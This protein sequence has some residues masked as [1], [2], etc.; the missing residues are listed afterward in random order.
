MYMKVLFPLPLTRN[1]YSTC[2][3]FQA[4][5]FCQVRS[6]RIFQ[7]SNYHSMFSLTFLSFILFPEQEVH[8]RDKDKIREIVSHC[9]VVINLMGQDYQTRNFSF[10]DIHI[11]VPR[12]LAKICKEEKV[13][14]FIHI[15]ALGAEL[16]SRSKFLRTKVTIF[17]Q[18]IKFVC[19]S[20]SFLL[21][22]LT[23]WKGFLCCDSFIFVL[24]FN[25]PPS[26]VAI[27]S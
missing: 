25:L 16:G 24:S 2:P 6:R 19:F 1:H 9:N 17:L 14:R 20:D 18:K 5:Y 26:T 13:E 7:F 10:E 12:S 8:V 11:E 22:R 23:T 3:I 27:C 21:T 4:N 15:S